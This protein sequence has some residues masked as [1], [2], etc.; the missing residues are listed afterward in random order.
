MFLRP[1][2]VVTGAT[3][4]QNASD[5]PPATA[6][7]P[8]AA[9]V[10]SR[11]FGRDMI[12][13]LLWG[14]QMAIATL[15]TPVVT[16]VLGPDK[17]GVVAASMTVMQLLVAVGS[18]G[19]QN[20][21]QRDFAQRGEREARRLV[22]VATLAAI[23][24]CAVAFVSE[25]AWAPALGLGS[26]SSAVRYAV[27]WA[28]CTAVTDAGL[29]LMRSR[30]QLML[31]AVVNLMQTA[32]AQAISL[33]LVLTVHRSAQEYLLGQFASQAVTAVLAL[34]LIRPLLVRRAH[35]GVIRSGL[36]Y[37]LPLVPAAIANFVLAGSDRL[38]V[39]HDLGS[40][41]VA[42][43]A[44][45]YNI[46][47]I[48]ILLLT[49]LSMTWMPRVFQVRD[50]TT[51][52]TVLRH[53]RDAL[54][55][56]L[57]PLSLMLSALT[58]LL[59]RAWAPPTYLQSSSVLIT[60][61]LVV[62]CIPFA[63]FVAHSR[64]LSAGSRTGPIAIVTL[65]G[66]AF[67]LAL[68][69]ALVP[70]AGI[71]GSAAATLAAYCAM[72]LA[73]GRLTPASLRLPPSNARLSHALLACVVVCGASATLPWNIPIVTLRSV[74]AIGSGLLFVRVLL[75]IARSPDP[76]DRHAEASGVLRTLGLTF[77]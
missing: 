9:S 25:P 4:G 33:V 15:I 16:R 26:H 69:V 35:L 71:V 30:D 12:Y 47:S 45:A 18:L 55:G 65:S 13:V 68:N 7:D 74:A 32:A 41:P 6:S 59:L 50:G 52:A 27:A 66:A 76:A 56:L 70:S 62:T 53:S 46:G 51:R 17:F 11:L 10:V 36:R 48:P 5:R 37:C 54:Y 14:A 63:G 60:V 72:H 29:A 61:I 34:A 23:L 21:V 3:T 31:F 8:N 42:R 28:G 67:N 22:T 58:P 43:Y 1:M 20:A 24:V 39:Q 77:E 64:V 75:S 57:I 49:A 38:V 44:V 73:L 40:I 19:L 2:G